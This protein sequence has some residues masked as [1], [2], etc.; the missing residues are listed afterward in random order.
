MTRFRTALNFLLTAVA[1]GVCLNCNGSSSASVAP[2]PAAVSAL[3]KTEAL[4]QR[5]LTDS[6]TA[7]GD[8]TTGQVVAISFPRAGQVSSLLVVPGQRVKPGAPLVTLT[9]DPNAKVAYAQAVSAAD[10][11]RGELQ[12]NEELLTL[13]LAT[14]SQVDASR[15]I[16][17]DAE[18]SLAA[19]RQLGGDVGTATVPAPFD[20]VVTAVA[21]A[22]GDRIQPG[23]T[24]L[25]LGH[26]DVLRVQLGIEPADFHLVRAG[27]AVTLSPVDDGTKSV[28]ASI[29]ENQGLVDPKT[30]LVD[31]LV[32]VP[33]ARASFLVPG[34]H[35]R[36]AIT[37]GQHLS[38]AVP[39][40]AVLTDANGAYV[41]QVSGDKAHRVNVTSGSESQ[42][43]VAIS[44]GIDPHQPVVVVGNY[45][46]Q[47]GMQV[48]LGQ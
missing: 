48:R 30:Q 17:Q 29:A 4:Q 39:R 15:K 8:V 14:Q 34:M 36:A 37:V 26:T 27:M 45:E 33:A 11:A 28:S 13:Q 40:A 19:Q 10:F 16:L 9:S 1:A 44:G 47:E 3:V 21:I 46:L 31:T 43:L 41:F 32:E 24:I 6:L 12:R 20:G 22:Q 2:A 7:F 38:W 5:S 23:A 42:G 35:V 18:A 25:Q